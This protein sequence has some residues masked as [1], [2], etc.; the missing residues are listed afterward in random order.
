MFRSSTEAHWTHW[1]LSAVSTHRDR[2]SSI[3]PMRSCSLAMC[4][5]ASQRGRRASSLP[6]ALFPCPPARTRLNLKLLSAITSVFVQ[7]RTLQ[8]C[9]STTTVT[10]FEMRFY[11]FDIA[12]SE[13]QKGFSGLLN[14]LAPDKPS[15]TLRYRAKS[16][17]G[18]NRKHYGVQS[19]Y[20]PTKRSA[21]S[22]NQQDTEAIRGERAAHQ[23]A[24]ETWIGHF[25]HQHLEF[26][27]SSDIHLV[28]E[29]EIGRDP[30]YA[31]SA[32]SSFTIIANIYT[33]RWINNGKWPW[34]IV[35]PNGKAKRVKLAVKERSRSK[36]IAT[37]KREKT[38]CWC[39]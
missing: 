11:L 16:C 19:D 33:P 23:Q 5:R 18:H 13:P 22:I 2:G 12:A 8:A 27:N 35:A 9:L 7:E 24:T 26:I 34:V 15:G 29:E 3:P 28:Y 6:E 30:V 4:S 37:G 32:D 39:Y 14:F 36:E 20:V 1:W 17:K 31:R 10:V 21:E 38:D 25:A